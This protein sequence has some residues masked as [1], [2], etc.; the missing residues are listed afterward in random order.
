MTRWAR[1]I[2]VVFLAVF[3]G[4]QFVRADRTNPPA[5][6]GDSLQ[7]K[8][9]PDVHAILDR[10]CRD[11]HSS[12]TRWPWYS[13]VAP[14]SWM[15]ASHVQNGREHFNYSEWTLYP[16]DDQDKF[17]NAMCNLTKRGRMPLPSYLLLHREA[18]LSAAD[19]AAVC[20]WSDKM[21]DTLQ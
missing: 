20:A 17:L 13:H 3:I 5:R 10:S 16:S 4:V 12:D 19:V 9:P 18:R 11:C 6:P 14:L 7:A 8:T 2:L 1:S 15:L 21:R